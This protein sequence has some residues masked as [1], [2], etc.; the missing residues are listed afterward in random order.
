MQQLRFIWDHLGR[1][2]KWIL[3]GCLLMTK[4]TDVL[5]WLPDRWKQH[6]EWLFPSWSWIW[7][8]VILLSLVAAFV[9]E[10]SYFREHPQQANPGKKDLRLP[11][12]ALAAIGLFWVSNV[13]WER[14]QS[15]HAAPTVAEGIPPS[16]TTAP[17]QP[18]PVQ[19]VAKPA[20]PKIQDAPATNAPPIV[21]H[22][23]KPKQPKPAP[24]VATAQ[25]APVNP[26]P[27]APAPAA[28]AQS[29][30]QQPTYSQKCEG[31]N[32][33]QGD[34]NGTLNQQLNQFG[35]AQWEA[36]LDGDK[37][38]TLIWASG[39]HRESSNYLAVSRCRRNEDGWI[40]GLC[41]YAGEMDI[42]RTRQ[43]RGKH[44]LSN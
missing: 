4:A 1:L 21:H 23:E 39:G 17:A 38:K 5:G 15:H 16:S 14:V 6:L 20:L 19:P 27:A 35:A 36:I 9:I 42:R 34:N 31:S 8:L 12:Y 18:T 33:F 41:V 32:C 43:V 22:V 25:S 44:V 24:P 2:R 11:T 10:E 37:Q 28:P 3:A 26:A 40:F 7:W 13:V 29:S 30:P